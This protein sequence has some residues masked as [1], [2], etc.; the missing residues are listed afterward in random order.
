[1]KKFI[2]SICLLLSLIVVAS[3]CGCQKE[4]PKIVSLATIVYTEVLESQDNTEWKMVLVP[5]Q[6]GANYEVTSLGG[7][8]LPDE[9]GVD[10]HGEEVVIEKGDLIIMEF[11]ESI[12]I[13]QETDPKVFIEGPVNTKRVSQNYTFEEVDG[14]YKFVIPLLDIY[15]GQLAKKDRTLEFYTYKSSEKP[16]ETAP[17]SAVIEDIS[18][19]VNDRTEGYVTFFV[20]SDKASVVIKSLAFGNVWVTVNG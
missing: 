12:Y 16:T 18:Q 20:A 3:F 2:K 15:N 19:I 14:G 10:E 8:V 6:A 5:V 4:E 11:E 1:M 9:K 7:A 17:Y 13:R